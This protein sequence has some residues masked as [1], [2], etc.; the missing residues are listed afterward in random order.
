[1][2][3][4]RGR[5]DANTPRGHRRV[6]RISMS[7]PQR[8][9]I[10]VDHLVAERGFGSRS[11]AIGEMLQ[12]QLLEHKREGGRGIMVGTIT[13]VYDHATPGLQQQLGD[14][15]RRHVDEVISSLHVQLMHEQTMEVILVQGPAP[16]LERLVDAIG[17]H[18][19]VVCC[20]MHLI[21]ALIP[22]LHPFLNA[23]AP[24]LGG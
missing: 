6:S 9:L 2:T 17:S 5:P 15:Q 22:P 16:T 14:L 1:M 11:Q 18:R 13:L 4:P 24:P 3:N 8:L 7:L 12:Q 20:R 10:E 23:A 21:A 19:G